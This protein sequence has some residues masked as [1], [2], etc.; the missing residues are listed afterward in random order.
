MPLIKSFVVG[1]IILLIVTVPASLNDW[2]NSGNQTNTLFFWIQVA[3][4]ICANIPGIVCADIFFV[5]WD[6]W[7]I[8]REQLMFGILL[9]LISLLSIRFSLLL[10]FNIISIESVYEGFR[11]VFAR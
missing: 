5:A 7:M 8:K 4:T 6:E 3:L 9:G 11:N 2:F 1:L 10:S